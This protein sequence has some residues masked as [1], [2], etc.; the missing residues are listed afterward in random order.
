MNQPAQE[1]HLGGIG[2]SIPTDQPEPYGTAE[3]DSTTI[4]IVEAHAGELACE[5]DAA[6]GASVLVVEEPE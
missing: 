6:T 4:V 5:L 1:L 2:V 3:W